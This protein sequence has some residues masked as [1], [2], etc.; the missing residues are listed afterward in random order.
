MREKGPDECAGDW[1]GRRTIGRGDLRSGALALA[2]QDGQ[3]GVRRLQRRIVLGEE[4]PAAIERTDDATHVRQSRWHGREVGGAHRTPADPCEDWH[5]TTRSSI[6]AFEAAMLVR[7]RLRLRLRELCLLSR[8]SCEQPFL[9]YFYSTRATVKYSTQHRSISCAGVLKSCRCRPTQRMAPSSPPASATAAPGATPR[10][11]P[12]MTSRCT[13][14]MRHGWR[15]RRPAATRS[16]SIHADRMVTARS[17]IP[18]A[19]R[20]LPPLEG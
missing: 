20:G 5:M 8:S 3:L 11:S 13:S 15:V 7:V 2:Q 17:T 16:T 18:S 9:K 6:S 1:P 10:P 19:R 4:L 12:S 14:T